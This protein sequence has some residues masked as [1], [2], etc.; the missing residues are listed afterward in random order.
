[1]KVDSDNE[2]GVLPQYTQNSSSSHLDTPSLESTFDAL[3]KSLYR[4]NAE[5]YSE[6][7]FLSIATPALRVLTCN[8][9]LACFER[10]QDLYTHEMEHLAGTHKCPNCNMVFTLKT[11]LK[12]HV[13]SAHL[14]ESA[15]KKYPC[16]TC[17]KEFYTKSDRKR[18][19]ETHQRKKPFKCEICG[20]GFGQK[21]NLKS[22][23]KTVHRR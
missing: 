18:H 16:S 14:V 9:C 6:E 4:Y 19:Q 8:V 5:L 10:E 23:V 12:R 20:S 17:R 1:M 13:E 11:N 22:H 2:H 7:L 3:R 15:R 21:S